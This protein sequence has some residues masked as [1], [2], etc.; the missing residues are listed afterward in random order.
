MSAHETI[1]NRLVAEGITEDIYYEQSEGGANRPYIVILQDNTEPHNTHNGASTFDRVQCRVLSFGDR[2]IT[3]GAVK[4]AKTLANEVRAALDY[5][6]VQGTNE[7]YFQNEQTDSI[8]D[9]GNK[10]AFM[11]EQTY[12]VWLNR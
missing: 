7:V 10:R 3:S 6:V 11:V 8:E 9:K 5:F 2:L 4:G 1:Y 12:D